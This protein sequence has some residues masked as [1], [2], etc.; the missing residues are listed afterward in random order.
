MLL[1]R[2]FVW[3]AQVIRAYVVDVW[4]RGVI[5]FRVSFMGLV[6]LWH[7]SGLGFKFGFRQLGLAAFRFPFCSWGVGFEAAWV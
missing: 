6:T 4:L 2:V 1:T 3:L 5:G 7:L